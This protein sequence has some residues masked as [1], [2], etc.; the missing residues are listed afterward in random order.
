MFDP[1]ISKKYHVWVGNTI[2]GVVWISLEH[3]C[4]TA[5]FRGTSRCHAKYKRCYAPLYR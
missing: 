4:H 2:I 5:F 1:D 3:D